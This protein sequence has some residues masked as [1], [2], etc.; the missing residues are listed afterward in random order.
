[1]R[2]KKVKDK[3]RQHSMF[4]VSIP[5]F[6]LSVAIGFF[7]VIMGIATS[8][9]WYFAIAGHFFAFAALRFIIVFYKFFVLHKTEEKEI[10]LHIAIGV[11]LLVLTLSLSLTIFMIMKSGRPK[12][13]GTIPA[14]ISAL[15]STIKVAGALRK[16]KK[17]YKKD[18]YL[19]RTIRNINMAETIVSLI[20]LAATM[21]TTFGDGKLESP[22]FLASAAVLCILILVLGIRMIGGGLSK[23]IAL[24][25]SRNYLPEQ[26]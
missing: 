5:A 6:L 18:N 7:N 14:I 16:L 9:G 21:I 24:K 22:T 19:K 26:E 20:V 23:K 13:L 3:A 12:V 4:T 25:K 2:E 10:N 15:H 11:L 1:M 17:A 8:S